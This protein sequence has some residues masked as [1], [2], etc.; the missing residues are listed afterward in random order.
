MGSQ[1]HILVSSTRPVRVKGAS[2]YGSRP[3]KNEEIM[4][5]LLKGVGVNPTHIKLNNDLS[6]I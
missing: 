5:P 2:Y 6:P 3:L 1:T 4:V